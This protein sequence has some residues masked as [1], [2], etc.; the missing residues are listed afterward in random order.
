MNMQVSQPP[1]VPRKY[2]LLFFIL[3]CFIY[4]FLLFLEP[5]NMA[6]PFI[7]INSVPALRPILPPKMNNYQYQ[8][9]GGMNM[10]PYHHLGNPPNPHPPN[11]IPTLPTQPVAP[12]TE[13][14]LSSLFENANRVNDAQKAVVSDFMYGK[15]K[16]PPDPNNP[17]S[18]LLLH[19]EEIKTDDGRLWSE[20]ILFEINYTSG[21]W[22][23]L[24]RRKPLQ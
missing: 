17:I 24:R 2:F 7:G 10:I 11:N 21:T 13:D 14:I 4:I 20:Q 19:E 18:Q 5:H 12:S 9:P 8:T 3:F 16:V 1:S 23:K 6:R 22:R 15:S